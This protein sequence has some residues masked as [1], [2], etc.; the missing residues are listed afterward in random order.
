MSN[1]TTEQL[2]IHLFSKK[3]INIV[4]DVPLNKVHV[5]KQ[6]LYDY[7]KKIDGVISSTAVPKKYRKFVSKLSRYV[8]EITPAQDKRIVGLT[9]LINQKCNMRC[10][11]CYGKD[12]SYGAPISDECMS[13]EMLFNTIDYLMKISGDAPVLN[14]TFFGGEPLLS[15]D[16]MK[17]GIKYARQRAKECNK[18][19]L[20]NFITNGILLSPDKIKFFMDNDIYVAISVDGDK[21]ANDQAR[22][23]GNK[24]HH[25]TV[26]KNLKPF[27]DKFAVSIRA[28]I[29]RHNYKEINKAIT[30]FSNQGWNKMIFEAVAEGG[31]DDIL[32]TDENLKELSGIYEEVFDRLTD[33]IGL[34]EKK[35]VGP[36]TMAFLRIAFKKQ[37][38]YHFC[39]AGRWSVAVDTQ[40]NVYPCHRL[41]GNEEYIVGNVTKNLDTSVFDNFFEADINSRKDCKTCWARYLC[42]G[43]CLRESMINGDIMKTLPENC[44]SIKA[45]TEMGLYSFA[46]LG[47]FKLLPKIPA[48]FSP[49]IAK[50][51]ILPLALR[52]MEEA[53]SMP[54]HRWRYSDYSRIIKSYK[55]K[56]G[57][58]SDSNLEIS[59]PPSQ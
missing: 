19:I 15:F 17:S 11:Y 57:K 16:L 56:G 20:L 31:S 28:T 2:D 37:K 4:Y 39:S 58:I 25:D 6:D 10:V 32:L 53:K 27:K 50:L 45:M 29:T 35:I 3:G 51:K 33:D 48:F 23:Y 47:W 42:G 12:G 5:V 26:I 13:E 14:F 34:F 46:R 22:K 54:G 8:E 40:G 7:L 55:D 44:E 41:I 59:L 38:D 1:N 30:H 36:F 52:G 49:N 43:G 9:A 21:E 18:E 24:S